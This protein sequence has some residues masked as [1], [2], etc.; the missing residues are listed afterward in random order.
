[1]LDALVDVRDNLWER[2]RLLECLESGLH[3]LVSL[4]QDFPYKGFKNTVCPFQYFEYT[5][6]LLE[7]S[8]ILSFP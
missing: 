7:W 6:N 2:D 8:K 5:K 3:G 4:I 1:V